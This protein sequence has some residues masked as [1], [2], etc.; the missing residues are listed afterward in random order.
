MANLWLGSVG[1]LWSQ[2]IG[3]SWK[4]CVTQLT[5]G[6]R[7]LSDTEVGSWGTTSSSLHWKWSL[8][9]ICRAALRQ[10]ASSF[11]RQEILSWTQLPQS[12]F[13]RDFKQDS[14]GKEVV[15]FNKIS[16]VLQHNTASI[17]RDILL[18]TSTGGLFAFTHTWPKKY[19]TNIPKVWKGWKVWLL[20]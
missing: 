11:R 20:T 17:V 4:S 16:L 18:F 2:L 5:T 9:P 7:L 14:Q 10:I 13:Q 1:S 15:T 19:V 6:K 3:C 8:G 12:Q